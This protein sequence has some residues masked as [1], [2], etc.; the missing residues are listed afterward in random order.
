[1]ENKDKVEQVPQ[2]TC[3]EEPIQQ[4]QPKEKNNKGKVW[5][6]ISFCN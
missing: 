6:Y 5:V 4:E 1:M 3:P 2:K